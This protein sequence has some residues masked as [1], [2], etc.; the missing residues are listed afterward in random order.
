MS[1]DTADHVITDIGAD[2][3]GQKD[4]QHLRKIT[5]RL[6]DR[7][8]KQ[9]LLMH[10]VL[11]NAG[12]SSGDNYAF[13]EEQG[14]QSYLPPHRKYKG[15]P[16][17]L[18]FEKEGNYWE[19]SQVK[20]VTFKKTFF[21]RGLKKNQYATIR[22][23]CRDCPIRTKCIGKSHEKRFNITYCKD[24]Y[25]RAI[26]RLKTKQGR[27]FKYVRSSTVEPVFG[28]LPQF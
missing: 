14:L 23:D 3:A 22:K 7:L 12:Y 6:K 9:G 2:F 17:G 21:E 24:E 15:G 10:N 28:S 19:C 11:A 26:T 25:D 20:R 1:V 4:S 13:F 18:R 5:L 27:C 8:N 16:S